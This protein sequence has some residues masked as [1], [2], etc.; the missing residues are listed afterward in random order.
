M[1]LRPVLQKLMG[2]SPTSKY[3]NAGSLFPAAE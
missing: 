2:M 1:G 3:E